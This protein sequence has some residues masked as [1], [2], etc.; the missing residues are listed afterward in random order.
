MVVLGPY[1]AIPADFNWRPDTP[2]SLS[3]GQIPHIVPTAKFVSITDDP[4][5]EI[6][7]WKKMKNWKCIELLSKIRRQT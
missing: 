3:P 6:E 5:I 1:T 2:V 4:S 7:K